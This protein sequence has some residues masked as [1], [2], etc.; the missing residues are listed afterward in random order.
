MEVQQ[1]LLFALWGIP[2]ATFVW[3]GKKFIV[4]PGSSLSLAEEV[5]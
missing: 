4:S 3:H 1:Q 2:S 5:S